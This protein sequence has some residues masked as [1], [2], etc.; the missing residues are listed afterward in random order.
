MLGVLPLQIQVAQHL[1]I[2]AMT[3]V[4]SFNTSQCGNMLLHRNAIL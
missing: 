4:V 1:N 2:I 3:A